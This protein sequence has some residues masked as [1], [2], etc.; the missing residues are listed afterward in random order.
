MPLAPLPVRVIESA[1]RK[2]T[3]SA[4]IVDDTI[5]VRVPAHMRAAERERHVADLVRRLEKKRAKGTVDLAARARELARRHDLPE[6][7]TIVWSEA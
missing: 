1:R 4:R 6:P 3:V 5:E 2:K 7:T